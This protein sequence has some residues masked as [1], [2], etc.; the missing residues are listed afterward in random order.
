MRLIV[1]APLLA[2]FSQ[3]ISLSPGKAPAVQLQRRYDDGK[4]HPTKYD[5]PGTSRPRYS[6]RGGGY[7][8]NR[9]SA[10]RRHQPRYRYPPRRHHHRHRQRRYDY[11]SYGGYGGGRVFITKREM[12]KAVRAAGY[13]IHITDRIYH[14]FLKAIAHAGITSKIELAMFLTQVLWESGGLRHKAEIRC[15]ET[16]CPGEYRH[17]GDPE[18]RFY[19]GRG[20]LQLTW[21]YNYKKCSRDLFGNDSLFRHPDWVER[22]EFLAWATAAWFWKHNVHRKLRHHMFGYSTQYING[23]LECKRW[24]AKNEEVS[25]GPFA[26]KA[27]K[28]FNHYQ[29][30]YRALNLPGKPIGGGCLFHIPPEFDEPQG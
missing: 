17:P 12:A 15:R 8:S 18:G 3:C 6:G 16:K 7:R 14:G 21:S 28:R 22:S 19:Y 2:L 23:D 25:P 1:L 11:A 9:Y 24:R 20:Y 26:Q 4:W 30:V 27:E 10:G 13:H 29:R 5:R